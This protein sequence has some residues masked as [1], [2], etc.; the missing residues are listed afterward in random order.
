MPQ[1]ISERPETTR[2]DP[3]IGASIE[4]VV[5]VDSDSMN[6]AE[7]WITVHEGR[8]IDSLDHGLLEIEIPEVH[9]SALC[10]LGYVLSVE[11]TDETIRVPN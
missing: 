6:A 9:V 1:F 5:R 8:L 4:L 2:N 7:E 3:T 10:D 11:S